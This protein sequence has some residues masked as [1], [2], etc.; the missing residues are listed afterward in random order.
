MILTLSSMVGYSSSF[1]R[2]TVAFSWLALAVT[3]ASNDPCVQNDDYCDCGNDEPETNAC[4]FYTSDQF[5]C[6]SQIFQNQKIPLSRVNDGICDC[7]DGSD[8]NVACE[9]DCIERERYRVEVIEKEENQRKNGLLAKDKLIK[10]AQSLYETKL[11]EG[12]EAKNMAKELQS[13]VDTMKGEVAD[14]TK[15]E[16]TENQLAVEDNMAL[17]EDYKTRF[18][19]TMTRD[20]L[21]TALTHGT[22]HGGQAVLE[23][24][25]LNAEKQL[26]DS[27]NT[28]EAD[29]ASN[30]LNDFVVLR[31]ASKE[32]TGAV[33][34][35]GEIQSLADNLLLHLALESLDTSVLSELVFD[36]YDR[37]Y[38]DCEE[39]SFFTRKGSGQSAID[40]ACD[41]M[42]NYMLKK[43]ERME[44]VEDL[45]A[46]LEQ[47][48]SELSRLESEFKNVKQKSVDY[49]DMLKK[50]F[51][52]DHVLFLY[53]KKCFEAQIDKYYYSVC[54]FTNA[55]Q[56]GT[57]LGKYD[58]LEKRNDEIVIHYKF[59][60]MC[61]ATK[62]PRLFTLSMR[63]GVEAKLMEVS[64]PET[65]SYSAI[66]ETP[67]AC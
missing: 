4:S 54:P 51:G 11:A 7:C 33:D 13:K 46:K 55:K 37:L 61:F 45:R 29:K 36:I 39:G 47:K 28:I 23:A 22:L 31:D 44:P 53:Y 42:K 15:L 12:L 1:I 67:L 49:D 59:G 40:I 43:N 63:C 19:A 27:S 14:A 9:N 30:V 56:D 32:S 18:A 57:T 64:E 60:D 6:K 50:D 24:V 17:A 25:I 52:T 34:S 62:R 38:I 8:E 65:C 5:H 16:Y 2:C 41:V 66:L 3:K 58:S 35:G 26:S 20:V 21:L 48:R 10:E